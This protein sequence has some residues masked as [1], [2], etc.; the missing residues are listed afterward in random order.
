MDKVWEMPD[1]CVC[2]SHPFP[3]VL[4]PEKQGIESHRHMASMSS[5][6]PPKAQLPSSALSAHKTCG[7][8]K[9]CHDVTS[10]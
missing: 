2:G 6:G 3:T 7:P 4:V 1:R 5:L 8:W 9:G 10:R